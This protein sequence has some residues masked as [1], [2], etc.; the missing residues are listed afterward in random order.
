LQRFESPFV[1]QAIRKPIVYCVNCRV[2]DQF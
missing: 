2:F 1:V